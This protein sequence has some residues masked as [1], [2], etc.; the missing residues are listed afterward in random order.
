M[1]TKVLSLVM[2]VSLFLSGCSS[3]FGPKIV[4]KWANKTQPAITLEIVQTGNQFILLQRGSRTPLAGTAENLSIG[5]RPIVLT[6]EDVL[7]VP[8]FMG[9]AEYVRAD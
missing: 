3:L 6:D 7:L 5:G 8:T 2:L 4:G 1:K 9:T